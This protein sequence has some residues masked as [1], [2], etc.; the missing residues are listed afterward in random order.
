MIK[1]ITKLLHPK[2]INKNQIVYFQTNQSGDVE[3]I[4]SDENF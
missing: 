2:L 3:D 1:K 4:P